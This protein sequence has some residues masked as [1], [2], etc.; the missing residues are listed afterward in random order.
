MASRNVQTGFPRAS[1]WSRLLKLAERIVPRQA[2]DG[3]DDVANG[4]WQAEVLREGPLQRRF[5][6]EGYV[7]LPPLDQDSLAALQ[8]Q[9]PGLLP[10]EMWSPAAAGS[11]YH[12]S[13]MHADEERRSRVQ[14][15][16]APV[17]EAYVREH[18][19]GY[20]VLHAAL[21]VK[22]PGGGRLPLHMNWSS[23]ADLNQSTVTLWCPLVDVGPKNGTLEVV[24]RSHRIT[25]R[26]EDMTP[27]YFDAYRDL[28][29][30]MAVAQSARAGEV[31]LMED[32][33]LHQSQSNRSNQP[34][35]A[36]QIVCV[37][38][39]ATTVFYYEA[40]PELYEVI[41]AD[42]DFFVRF[43]ISSVQ[44]RQEGW[45]SLGFVRRPDDSLDAAE[46][47][48]RMKNPAEIRRGG[49]RLEP[50]AGGSEAL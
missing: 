18:L 21:H 44:V 36:A 19:K 47:L 26:I 17:F 24:P 32:T 13:F 15:V 2:T 38:D 6:T 22:P 10:G 42:R 33:L 27:R 5:E 35:I 49:F 31:V 25:R 43:D 34:R 39:T 7:R 45:R 41:E 40:T 48:R 4:G 46:C 20:R 29:S 12:C 28:L 9:A 37:P 1:G 30:G 23:V 14:E 16:F 3:D 11:Q 8:E 50:V